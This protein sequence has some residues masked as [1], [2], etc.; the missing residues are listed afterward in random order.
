MID[1]LL[2]WLARFAMG[3]NFYQAHNDI[4]V[5]GQAENNRYLE[6]VISG[7]GTHTV[8]NE[9]NDEHYTSLINAYD[10]PVEGIVYVQG[11]AYV[12][13]TI[14]GRVSVV[15]SD[16]IM[17][18]DSCV[19][20]NGLDHADDSD[21]AA[22]LARDKLFF[23]GTDLNVCGIFYAERIAS[24][25][26]AFDAAYDVNGDYNV[27]VYVTRFDGRP[28]D[29]S[30]LR[31]RWSILDGKRKQSFYEKHTIVSHPTVDDTT[32]ALIAAKSNTIADLS[33]EIATAIVEV[34][35]VHPPG[36]KKK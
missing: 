25:N 11:D 10:L 1:R 8:V 24:S 4:P 31:A 16:D 12:R 17:F 3:L 23:C 18:Q 29:K 36:K 35:R 2:R 26:P 28:G 33:R 6:F 15:S 32:E 14:K 20:A 7:D 27:T 34:S 9:Y 19:Y 30:H 13:G 22:Y 5:F 21:A